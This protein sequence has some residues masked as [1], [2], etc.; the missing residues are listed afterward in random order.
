MSLMDKIRKESEAP[1]VVIVKREDPL[2][3]EFHIEHDELGS[4]TPIQSASFEESLLKELEKI[5][6]VS[7]KKVGVRLEEKILSDIQDLCRDNNITVETLLESFYETCISRDSIMKLVIK[8]A[9]ARMKRRT[10]A[11]NIRS[12]LTKFRNI[13]NH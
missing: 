3:D 9:Q 2:L 6:L 7:S 11:G 8:D 4:Q 12:T 5:P 10:R 1:S 13:Q